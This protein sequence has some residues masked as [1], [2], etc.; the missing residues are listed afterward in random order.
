MQLER[1][2]TL[3]NAKVGLRFLAMERSLRAT[4]CDLPLLVIPYDETRFALPSG[5]TWW[6]LPEVTSWLKGWKSHPTMRKYQCLTTTNF[7][8]VDADVVFLRNPA[9][10]LTTPTGFVTSCGHWHNPGQTYTQ[11]SLPILKRLSTT[12]QMRI[13]NTGQWA[14]DERLYTFAELVRQAEQ[15]DHSSTCLRFPYHEQ[16]GVNLLV[17]SAGI[18]I[19]NLT[20]PPF[21]MESTWAGDYLAADYETYWSPPDQKPYLIHWAGVPMETARPIDDLFYNFLTRAELAEWRDQLAVAT[22]AKV[23]RRNSLRSRAA[24]V[25]HAGLNFW[26]GI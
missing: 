22:A 12:W 19:H 14:C 26:A 8:F 2:I 9:E 18:S 16:P 6:E 1:I 11:D 4:G 21:R 25:K 3:A 5:A 20:L 15:A 24:R 17:N 7:Q 23:R 10:V 13:F